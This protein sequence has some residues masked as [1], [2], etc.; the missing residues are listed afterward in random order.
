ML[1]YLT[2]LLCTFML[3]TTTS[4]VHA[5]TTVGGERPSDGYFDPERDPILSMVN[6]KMRFVVSEDVLVRATD[7]RFTQI[8]QIEAVYKKQ[9]YEDWYVFM[10]GRERDHIEQSVIIVLKLRRDENNNY[11]ADH[12][13]NACV[14]DSCGSCGFD[15]TRLRGCFCKSEDP[16]SKAGTSGFC[17]NIWSDEALFRK[18][19]LKPQ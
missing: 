3:L 17:Y 4:V 6:G 12:F 9:L 5:Q 13:W 7:L 15:E 14:G 11:F 2:T 1:H 18:I 10:E 19:P 8:G 16:S